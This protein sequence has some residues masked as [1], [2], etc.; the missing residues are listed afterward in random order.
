MTDRA[1]LSDEL[2]AAFLELLFAY[3]EGTNV[4]LMMYPP[5]PGS[6][7]SQTTPIEACYERD[8]LREITDCAKRLRN[9]LG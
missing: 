3:I 2:R 6:I 7:E 9:S 1:P 4:H 5:P 8:F